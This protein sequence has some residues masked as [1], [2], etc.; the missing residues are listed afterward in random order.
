MA[1]TAY[2]AKPIKFTAIRLVAT[3]KVTRMGIVPAQ[4]GSHSGLQ[5]HQRRHEPVDVDA[6]GDTVV[7]ARAALP[8]PEDVVVPQLRR[9][10]V[11]LAPQNQQ[12]PLPHRA[13]PLPRHVAPYQWQTSQTGALNRLSFFFSLF[14]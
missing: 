3:D 14:Q 5:L 6:V 8:R 11:P 4:A 10:C 12:L 2:L 1:I 7:P 9:Y 13:G